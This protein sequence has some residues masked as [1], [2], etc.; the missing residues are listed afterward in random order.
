[1]RCIYEMCES[2]WRKSSVKVNLCGGVCGLYV[3]SVAV[4]IVDVYREIS[5]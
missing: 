5:V 3:V 2:E 1:M 4:Q